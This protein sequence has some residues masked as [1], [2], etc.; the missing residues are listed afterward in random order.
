M[1]KETTKKYEETQKKQKRSYKDD[2]LSAYG[3]GYAKGWEDAYT[4]PKRFGS[5][6]AATHGYK[7]G[8][9]NHYKSDKYA[10]QYNKY[11]N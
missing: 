1:S 11:K 5:V 10:S 7:K 4:I 3:I 9:K 8:I 2:I 6:A